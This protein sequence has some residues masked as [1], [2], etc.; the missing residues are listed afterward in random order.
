MRREWTV[1]G[2]NTEKYPGRRRWNFVP[3]QPSYGQPQSSEGARQGI[4]TF[5][6]VKTKVCVTHQEGRAPYQSNT[7]P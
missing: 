4:S 1:F 7:T 3:H 2:L 6:T 5:Y